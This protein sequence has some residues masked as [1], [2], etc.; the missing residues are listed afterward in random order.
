M[1]Q[2]R[3]FTTDCS[4]RATTVV[5]C[6]A[7]SLTTIRAPSATRRSQAPYR[8]W[9][10]RSSTVLHRASPTTSASTGTATCLKRDSTEPHHAREQLACSR[11]TGQSSSQPTEPPTATGRKTPR[12]QWATCWATGAKRSS[13]APATTNMCVSTQ[14]TWLRS[15]ATTP[16]GTT[17]STGRAWC[18]RAWATTSRLMPATTWVSWRT[19]PLLHH[20]SP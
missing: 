1:P 12:R 3:R 10:T 15:G 9:P 6:A 13:C 7:T 5:R 17:T 16:C 8:A 20:P 2:R 19:S 4:L 14:P 11:P 18:G